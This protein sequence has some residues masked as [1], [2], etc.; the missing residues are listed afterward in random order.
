MPVGRNSEAYCADH[1]G[2]WRNTLRYCALR[3][4]NRGTQLP[5]GLVVANAGNA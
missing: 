2:P 1:N 5:I 3:L 4:V